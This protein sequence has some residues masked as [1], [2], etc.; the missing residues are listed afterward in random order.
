M[1]V[2]KSFSDWCFDRRNQLPPEWTIVD[3]TTTDAKAKEHLRKRFETCYPFH[4]ATLSVFQRKW[5]S[6]PQYQQT[7]G[8]LAMLAQWISIAFRENYESAS[9]EP[10]ITLGSAPLEVPDFRNA[11]LGQLGEPRLVHAIEADIAG[12]TSH[13][14]ALDEDTKGPLENIHHKV[15]TSILFE[16]SGGMTDKAAHLPEIR[17]A[18]G[19]PGLDTTSID[20]AAQTL[21]RR[22]FYLRQMGKDGFRFGFQP[23]LKK[24]VG[25]RRASLDESEI[26]RA[27]KKLVRA[28]WEQSSPV[29]IVL[30]PE[31]N[32]DIPDKPKLTLVVVDPDKSLDDDIRKRLS[33]WTKTRADSRRLYPASIVWAVRR[34]GRELLDRVENY[35]AWKHVFDEI[36]SGLLGDFEQTERRNAQGEVRNA[37]EDARDEIWASYQYA[38]F[39]DGSE[40]DGLKLIALGAGHAS[41]GDSLAL[42]VVEAMKSEGLLNE[43]VGVSYLQRNWPTALKESGIWPLSGLRQSFLDGSLTRLI[44]PEDVLV[45]QIIRFVE[46]GDFGLGSGVR[47]DGTYENLWFNQPLR[48]EDVTFDSQT[49]LIL[50]DKAQ[51]LLSPPE[52][53]AQESTEESKVIQS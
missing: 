35:L 21:E 2:A 45:E 9:N 1:A 4:P 22:C 47:P 20:N 8:T 34:Q 40:K 10:L 11:V 53:R 30:F 19:E 18:V 23:T 42:R 29:P 3:S 5:Q 31:T 43:S 38:L 37:E 52:A 36:T 44:Y 46:G 7:R 33:S 51:S 50:K 12:E 26:K 24:V 49:F 32:E 41:A 39:Y 16:S 27:L 13:A 28:E 17:F 48:P 25:D 14:R 6:L 15:A